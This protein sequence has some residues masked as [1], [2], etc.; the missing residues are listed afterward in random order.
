MKRSLSEMANWGQTFILSGKPGSESPFGYNLAKIF[1]TARDV[2]L[3]RGL[4]P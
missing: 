2:Q 3:E 1:P 4:L